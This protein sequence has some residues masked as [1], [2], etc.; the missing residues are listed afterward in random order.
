[1]DGDAVHAGSGN[2]DKCNMENGRK[3]TFNIIRTTTAC[4]IHSKNKDPWP[5]LVSPKGGLPKVAVQSL[6]LKSKPSP[7][8]VKLA[9]W[10]YEKYES[11][12][13]VP[14]EKVW[15]AE[16]QTWHYGK[17]YYKQLKCLDVVYGGEKG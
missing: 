7:N 16:L 14:C 11:N 8:N 15:E 6:Y 12:S 1:M 10:G 4:T 5:N 3:K 13:W 2:G 17:F 9:T